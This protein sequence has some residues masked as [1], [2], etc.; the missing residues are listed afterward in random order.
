MR[1][2]YK[3]SPNSRRAKIMPENARI[4]NAALE[5]SEL[6]AGSGRLE[7]RLSSITGLGVGAVEKTLRNSPSLRLSIRSKIENWR[8]HKIGQAID[9]GCTTISQISR[10]TTFSRDMIRDVFTRRNC[11]SMLPANAI[12]VSARLSLGGQMGAATRV[13][14]TLN[15]V[16]FASKKSPKSLRSLAKEAG[17]SFQWLCKFRKSQ[18]II[19]AICLDILSRKRA[20]NFEEKARLA[21]GR[22][23]LIKHLD[24]SRQKEAR[25]IRQEIREEIEMEG[26]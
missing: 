1:G 18:P 4:I 26:Q 22:R 17:M 12:E 14:R 6:L 2:R 10:K 7:E 8:L 3:I 19:D 23:A 5:H 11:W 13:N 16:V 20:L 15:K 21:N 9:S 25:A 24:T